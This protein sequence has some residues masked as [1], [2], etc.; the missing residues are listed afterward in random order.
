M[1]CTFTTGFPLLALDARERHVLFVAIFTGGVRRSKNGKETRE[2]C[3]TRATH[4]PQRD[5]GGKRALGFWR[6]CPLTVPQSPQVCER[7]RR[8]QRPTPHER[9][10]QSRPARRDRSSGCASDTAS[11]HGMRERP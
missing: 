2:W 1:R 11:R 4:K 3:K 8:P 5:P 7:D 9:E 6:D 10:E